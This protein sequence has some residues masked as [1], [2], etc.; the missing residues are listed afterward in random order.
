MILKFHGREELGKKYPTRLFRKV[1]TK[2]K[3]Y[4]NTVVARSRQQSTGS[5]FAKYYAL[6]LHILKFISFMIQIE[7]HLITNV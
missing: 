6:L 3:T 1:I 4:E 7:I 2:N 5:Y